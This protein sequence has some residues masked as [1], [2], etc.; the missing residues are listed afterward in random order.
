MKLFFS[1][2]SALALVE[3]ADQIPRTF[4]TCP[5]VGGRGGKEFNNANKLEHGQKLTTLTICFG[6]RVDGL[7]VSFVPPSGMGQDLFYGSK[8]NCHSHQLASD[9]YITH[10]EAQTVKADD[11]T[12]VSYIRFMSNKGTYYEG[13]RETSNESNKAD[14][15]APEGYQLG[16]LYGRAGQE[17]DAVGPIWVKLN[18]EP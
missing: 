10:W 3:G 4:S 12:K 2:L 7:G 5:L 17:I 18:P 6:H 1:F 8:N 9:E 13:G 16:S 14:C 15:N 11:K